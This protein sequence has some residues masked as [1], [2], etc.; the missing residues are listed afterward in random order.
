MKKWTKGRYIWMDSQFLAS[1]SPSQPGGNVS[2]GTAVTLLVPQ[3]QIY[4]TLDG[5]DPRLPGGGIASAAQLYTAPVVVNSTAR[6]VARTYLNPTQLWT[7]WSA[8]TE[9][10][11]VVQTPKLVITEIM[12]HP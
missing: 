9:I 10:T 1:P 3:G 6:L 12:Y 2:L 5:T 8:T 7:P 4:Y 11:Y